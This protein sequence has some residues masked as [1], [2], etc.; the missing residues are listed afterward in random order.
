MD[1]IIGVGSATVIVFTFYFVLMGISKIM[2]DY[3]NDK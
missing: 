2:G 3:D 1:M